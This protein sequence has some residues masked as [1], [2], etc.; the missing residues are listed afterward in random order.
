V[1]AQ[2]LPAAANRFTFFAFA[3]IDH[4]VMEMA[5]E[6]TLHTILWNSVVHSAYGIQLF[7]LPQAL[8]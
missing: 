4:L 1:A 3:R 6:G 5:A 7:T 8:F 2:T